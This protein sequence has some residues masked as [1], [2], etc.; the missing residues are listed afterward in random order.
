MMAMT[1]DDVSCCDDDDDNNDDDDDDDDA[2]R[3]VTKYHLNPT[4][5]VFVTSSSK[6]AF[7]L[8]LLNVPLLYYC[9]IIY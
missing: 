6:E 3:M 1:N 7:W 8:D 4:T 2:S 5:N 9:H